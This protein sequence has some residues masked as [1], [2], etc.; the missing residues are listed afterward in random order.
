M[1]R[2]QQSFILLSKLIQKK[3]NRICKDRKASRMLTSIGVHMENGYP[4]T[5]EFEGKHLK[6]NSTYGYE[7]GKV[8]GLE[9]FVYQDNYVL[10]ID[11]LKCS[12]TIH[13]EVNEES[14]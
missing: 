12:Y 14:E 6:I 9:E 2:P 8:T 10:V 7:Y 5:I 1:E 4:T 11:L 3:Y 13:E